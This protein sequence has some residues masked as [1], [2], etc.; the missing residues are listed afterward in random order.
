MPI[1]SSFDQAT[2]D[3]EYSPSSCV[4][5]IDVYLDEYSTASRAAKDA[6]VE[7]GSCLIDLVYGTHVDEKL[8]LFLPNATGSAPLHIYIHGGYWQELSKEES[9]F[10]APV[11]Q[12]HGSFFATL[13]YSLAPVAN[14]SKIVAQNRRA[15]AWL[16]DQS[17]RW[18]FDRRQIYLSGSSAGAH[19]TM[20]MLL[21]DWTHYGLPEDAIKGV[22]AVSG[23]YDLEPIRLSYVNDVL[24]ASVEEVRCNSP[25][26]H[27][28]RNH[29]P[30]ILAY[31]ENETSEFK[32]QT[33]EY[34]ELLL[35]AGET[36]SCNEI[37]SRNHFNVIMDLADPDTW[38]SQQV[39]R[40][41]GL[42]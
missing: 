25:I 15:I 31:G 14:L 12:E 4:G 1:Y 9:S 10:A 29:C 18:G 39:I 17:I 42:S 6:A 22:C 37:R 16:Y 26:Q 32:R 41:M 27:T 13:D 11:F 19:L 8:D 2:L 36:V 35:N 33:D 5:D 24:G 34:K 20:M 7:Q 28:L 30:I 40:Q 23:I 3:R 21:T 38:I